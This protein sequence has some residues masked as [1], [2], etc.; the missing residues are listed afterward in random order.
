MSVSHNH[1]RKLIRKC[2]TESGGDPKKGYV[3]FREKV[4]KMV[5]DREGVGVPLLTAME[6]AASIQEH[7]RTERPGLLIV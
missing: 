3:L 5:K 7:A 4:D 2:R 1:R 6:A